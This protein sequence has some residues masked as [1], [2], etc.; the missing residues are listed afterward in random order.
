MPLK[1]NNVI[2]NVHCKKKWMERVKVHLNQPG[3]K[4][5]RRVNRAAVRPRSTSPLPP[6]PPPPLLFVVDP[7]TH[8]G[9]L[10]RSYSFGFKLYCIMLQR[11]KS[12]AKRKSFLF[13]KLT[14]VY[15]LFYSSS[16]SVSFSHPLPPSRNS[17]PLHHGQ[18]AEHSDLSSDAP[19][20]STT[21]RS[22]LDVVSHWASSRELASLPRRQEQ[23][24]LPSTTVE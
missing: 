24:A 13:L 21:Q 9:L 8:F 14:N 20:L 10:A 16:L 22:V 15:F 18:L 6:P 3:K 2:A 4:K 11:N 23:L 17:L 1:G 12:L 7:G 5:T 19:P